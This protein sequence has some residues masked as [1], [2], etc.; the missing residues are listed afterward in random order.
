MQMLTANPQ[1]NS[2]LK[3]DIKNALTQIEEGFEQVRNIRFC[4]D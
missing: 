3:Y 2:P 1:N 4:W